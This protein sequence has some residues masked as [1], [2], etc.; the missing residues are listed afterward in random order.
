MTSFIKHSIVYEP[1]RV[2]HLVTTGIFLS[3]RDFQKW[4]TGLFQKNPGPKPGYLP[5]RCRSRG[6]KNQ[7]GGC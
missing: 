2:S 4:A 1:Q 6:E 7:Q 3:Y 5:K